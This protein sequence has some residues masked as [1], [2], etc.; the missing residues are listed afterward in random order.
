VKRFGRL[1]DRVAALEARRA[2]DAWTCPPECPGR[3]MPFVEVEEGEEPPPEFECPAGSPHR[4]R[5][6]GAGMVRRVVVVMPRRGDADA[7]AA[8]DNR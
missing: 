1:R 7:T 5:C 4:R 3:A 8:Q 2:A 6:D